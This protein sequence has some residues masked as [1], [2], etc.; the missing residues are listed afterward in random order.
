V[1]EIEYPAQLN[2]DTWGRCV[3][4]SAFGAYLGT[5][6]AEPPVDRKVRL[7]VVAAL[8]AVWDYIPA[9]YR[10][11]V[12]ATEQYADD[13][14]AST[15]AAAGVEEPPESGEGLAYKLAWR[16]Y[17]AL[18]SDFADDRKWPLWV[19][20]A[21]K[22]AADP[23]PGRDPATARELHA[24]FFHDVFGNPFR[25]VALDRSLLTSTVVALARWMYESRD[26]SPMPILADALQE[27]GCEDQDVLNH[28]RGG[29][30]HI[31]GCWVVDQVLGKL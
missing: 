15:L 28:C 13:R 5:D 2:A 12:E 17:N 26:F 30:P 19:R 29:G 11:A 21:D 4:L 9:D 18:D 31:R 10:R 22:L 14:L 3:S 1:D 25:P 27:A 16:A 6:A 24:A 8:R 7:L 23:I 20:L